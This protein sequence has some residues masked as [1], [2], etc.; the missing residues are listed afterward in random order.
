[1]FGLQTSRKG[2]LIYSTSRRLSAPRDTSKRAASVRLAKP[3]L[4]FF[5]S[6]STTLLETRS[7]KALK[8]PALF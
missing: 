5:T 8:I 7:E 3:K 4:D 1:M 6:K 2:A